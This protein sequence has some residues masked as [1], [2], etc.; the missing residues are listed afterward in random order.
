MSLKDKTLLLKYKYIYNIYIHYQII[1]YI[2]IYIYNQEGSESLGINTSAG[3]YRATQGSVN[4]VKVI[5]TYSHNTT[6]CLIFNS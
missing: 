5:V 6:L 1:L 4:N 3:P 2:Y